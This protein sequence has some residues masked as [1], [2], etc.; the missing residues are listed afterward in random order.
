MNIVV[1]GASAAGLKAACRARRL[2]PDAK[3]KVV[4]KGKYISYSACGLPY[5]LS[6]D[7]D[8]FR[9]LNTTAYDVVKDPEYFLHT[10][11]VEVLTE[12]LAEHIEADK[13]VLLCCNLI[14]GES[15]SLKYDKLVIAA[16]ANPVVPPIPGADLP[17]V[18][19]FT[20]AEDAIELRKGLQT[21]QIGKAAVIGAGF[22]GCELTEAFTAMW[23]VETVLFEMLDRPLAKM[24]DP[25]M[26]AIVMREFS[27]NEIETHFGSAIKAI[28]GAGDTLKIITADGEFDGFDRV[29]IAAGVRPSVKLAETAGIVLGPLGG[30]KVDER[31]QTSVPGIYAAG[32]CI[33]VPQLLTGKSCHIPLGSLANRMGRVAGNNLAGK[34]DV[35]E[36]VVGSSCLKI[37][38]LNIAAAGLSFTGAKNAGFDPGE[39]WGVFTDRVHYYPEMELLTAKMVFDRRTRQI[40][41][42]QVVGKGEVIRRVDAV[43]SMIKER[44]TLEKVMNFEPAYA[45]PYA[46]ALDPLHFLA[47]AGIAGLEEGV[48]SFNPVEL[49]KRASDTVVLDV[50]ETIEIEE[51]PFPHPSKKLL[52]I[53]LTEI[54]ARLNEIP[55][56]TAV[57]VVCQRGTRSSEVVRILQENGWQDVAYLGGGLGFHLD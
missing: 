11:D 27:R 13:K 8:S 48:R 51:M 33:E 47:Y 39:S 26:A 50:R 12:T 46:N 29:I 7:V 23:G 57:S 31:M 37:L 32:D 3:V 44:V 35:F 54:R 53:P 45:P 28:E 40:L 19:T 25:E 14:E 34:D 16:G 2:L 20:K 38:D 9:E 21:G 1:I 41:G 18:Y 56:K 42:V 10:K 43:S 49:E 55:A 52:I 36:P 4:E 30:I 5:F 22:I 24:L 15:F 6:G 17:G